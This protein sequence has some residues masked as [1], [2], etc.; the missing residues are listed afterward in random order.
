MTAFGFA[1]AST[2]TTRSRQASP[3]PYGI[4]STSFK[5]LLWTRSSSNVSTLASIASTIN[6]GLWAPIRSFSVT[7]PNSKKRSRS[8]GQ[9]ESPTKR[10][11]RDSAAAMMD[12]EV[13]Y[14]NMPSP[15]HSSSAPRSP[16]SGWWTE[17][18]YD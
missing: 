4:L 12:V 7:V 10:G 13:G 14:R 6:Y 1:T 16:K 2:A 8:I 15:A 3:T 9:D 17:P 11:R 5:D 18:F